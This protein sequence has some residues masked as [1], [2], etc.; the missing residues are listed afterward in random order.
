[1]FVANDYHVIFV[2]LRPIFPRNVC[3]HGKRGGGIGHLIGGVWKLYTVQYMLGL[4]LVWCHHF[5]FFVMKMIC[6]Q[7]ESLKRITFVVLK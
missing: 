6:I 2:L 3:F 4:G 1:M 7:R 5:D